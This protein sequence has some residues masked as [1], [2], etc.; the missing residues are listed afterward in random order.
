M[1]EAEIY[2]SSRGPRGNTGIVGH[3]SVFKPQFASR[4]AQKADLQV[5]NPIPGLSV[6]RQTRFPK[7]P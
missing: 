6:D 1:T 4:K 7:R 2:A 3:E 5:T